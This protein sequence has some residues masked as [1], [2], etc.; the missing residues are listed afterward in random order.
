MIIPRKYGGGIVIGDKVRSYG[1][2][3]NDPIDTEKVNAAIQWSQKDSKYV[4]RWISTKSMVGQEVYVEYGARYWEMFYRD[5][6]N[7]DQLRR[8]YPTVINPFELNYR[9]EY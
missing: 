9:K 6:Q 4:I 7:M 1:P 2:Y 3:I 5:V 8:N